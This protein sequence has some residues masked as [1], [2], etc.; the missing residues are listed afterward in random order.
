MKVTRR[1]LKTLIKEEWQA[2]SDEPR[3][4]WTATQSSPNPFN[5]DGSNL[6]EI[7]A[8]I[9][10]PYQGWRNWS[11]EENNLERELQ[12]WI[13]KMFESS[14]NVLEEPH[15]SKVESEIKSQ[16]ARKADDM[17]AKLFGES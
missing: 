13:K 4:G 7:V 1:Q 2:I 8:T 5:V 3:L 17:I 16:Y 14:L 11:E 15:K 10:K 9:F 6:E 12:V